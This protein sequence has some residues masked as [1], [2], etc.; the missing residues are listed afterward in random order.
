MVRYLCV[1]RNSGL[2]TRNVRSK[3]DSPIFSVL[4]ARVTSHTEAEGDC[5]CGVPFSSVMKEEKE[6]E[7]EQEKAK[8][9]ATARER[10]GFVMREK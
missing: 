7:R 4:V 10:E 6:K 1:S 9:R 3:E 2:F 8:E 5:V